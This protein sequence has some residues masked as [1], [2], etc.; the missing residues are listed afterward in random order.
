MLKIWLK[1]ASLGGHSDHCVDVSG[2]CRPARPG[3]LIEGGANDAPTGSAMAIDTFASPLRLAPRRSW[4]SLLSRVG[5][6]VAHWLGRDEN[7]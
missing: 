3:S 2:A 7:V 6:K 1:N 5:E 4:R